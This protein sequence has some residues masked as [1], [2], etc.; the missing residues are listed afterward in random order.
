MIECEVSRVLFGINTRVLTLLRDA[1]TEHIT[2]DSQTIYIL[3]NLGDEWL[4]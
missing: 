1:I 2:D 4:S 3:K